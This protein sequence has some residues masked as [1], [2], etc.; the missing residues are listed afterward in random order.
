MHLVRS[1]LVSSTPHTDLVRQI[2]A[3]LSVWNQSQIHME[4]FF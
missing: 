2:S 1:V 3:Q 4:V